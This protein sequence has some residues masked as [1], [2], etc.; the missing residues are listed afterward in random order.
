M[1]KGTTNTEGIQAPGATLA[2]EA[3]NAAEVIRKDGT[4]EPRAVDKA[5]SLEDLFI[6][7]MNLL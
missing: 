5:C 1:S 7:I 6:L 4:S 2:D 3:E